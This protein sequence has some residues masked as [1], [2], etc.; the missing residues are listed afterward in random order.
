MFKKTLLYSTLIL[1]F[2]NFFVR[3]LG[4]IYRIIL[5]RIIGPQGMGLFQLIFPVYILANTLTSSGIGIAVSKLT[6]EYKVRRDNN[7]ILKTVFWAFIIVIIVSIILCLLVIFNINTIA[8]SFLKDIRTAR[9]LLILFPCIILTGL[10]SVL[11]GYFY[12]INNVSPSA[13]SDIVEQI[14]R[15]G[16]VFFILVNTCNLSDEKSAIIAVIGMIAGELLGLMFLYCLYILNLKKTFV[17]KFTRVRSHHIL[18][19]ILAISLPITFTRFF[20][21]IITSCNS[22]IIPQCLLISGMTQEEA[23]GTFGV[24]TGMVMPLIFLPFTIISALCVVIIPELSESSVLKKWPQIHDRI[25]KSIH[26][27]CLTAFLAMSV[28]SSYSHLIGNI[29]YKNTDVGKYLLPLSFSIIF[30][31]LKQSLASIL[32]GLGQQKIAS[33][34]FIIGNLVQIIFT[35]LLVANA[36]LNI[37]GFIIGLMANNLLVTYLNFSVVLKV[38]NL[39]IDS[40]KWFIE[41]GLVC[42]GSG[43]ICRFLLM[44]L[45]NIY[46]YSL[47]LSLFFI[48]ITPIFAILLLIILG[49]I[50]FKFFDRLW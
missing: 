14:T 35:F 4:F 43:L 47:L 7:S 31:C 5:S 46:G 23:I 39:Y 37:Y 6:A 41:P 2:A 20:A 19:N 25:S 16:V 13:L 24:V 8:N 40:F 34:H 27:T 28:L 15:I 30:L 18:K 10:S 17:S 36:R 3:I 48:F 50:R 1:S 22:I 42:M 44:F 29:L 38:T 32:N 33:F 12:G 11:K 9:P 49:N 21:S 26:I 45:F